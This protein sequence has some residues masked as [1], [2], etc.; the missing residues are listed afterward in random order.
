MENSTTYELPRVLADFP[1]Q[2]RVNG[3]FAR[4]LATDRIS[5]AYLFLGDAQLAGSYAQALAKCLI[6]PQGGEGACEECLRVD[7]GT[8]PDV[9]VLSPGSASGYLVGQIRDLISDVSLAPVRARNKVY[10]V[11]QAERLWGTSA[12]ALLKTL[13]EP[14]T[15]V[16]FVLAATSRDAVLDTIASRCQQIPFASAGTGGQD[17]QT[18]AAQEDPAVKELRDAAA[19]SVLGLGGMDSASV[20]RC[21]KELVD[22]AKSSVDELRDQQE[23]R[24]EGV[25]E[26]L[27]ARALKELADA[28]R[29]E[30]S[31]RERSG[32]MEVVAACESVV[33][34]LL[35]CCENR[36]SH[37]VNTGLEGSLLQLCRTLG[38]RDILRALDACELAAKRLS[39]G[40]T[41]QLTL[42]VML[43][44][45][46]EALYANRSTG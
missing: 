1:V 43:L 20:L 24:D 23:S 10:I 26:F 22:M 42:E 5:H 33:R 38:P 9:H 18:S 25:D 30:L 11:Q 40:V 15:H 6:C 41:P 37:I 4:A 39:G 13:E 17:A 36:E 27:T 29:R 8:H 45:V 12:N 19:A 28:N 32:M 44:Q 31:Q 34:D 46:K 16:V 3:Y 14:P 7:H 21:A 2:E 35:L